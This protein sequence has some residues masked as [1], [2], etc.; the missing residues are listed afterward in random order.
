MVP[1]VFGFIFSIRWTEGLLLHIFSFFFSLEQKTS[2]LNILAQCLREHVSLKSETRM[3]ASVLKQ[4]PYT[5][6]KNNVTK[7]FS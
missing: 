2:F 5:G 7:R 3:I 6:H 4:D 1:N